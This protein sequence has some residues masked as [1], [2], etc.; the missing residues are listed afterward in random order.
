MG[1]QSGAWKAL[2]TGQAA[3][4]SRKKRSGGERAQGALKGK[5]ETARQGSVEQRPMMVV[6]K[7]GEVLLKRRSN[8]GSL[9]AKRHAPT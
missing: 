6:V 4:N 8:K 1:K 3:P 9:V 7:S 2:R 5:K